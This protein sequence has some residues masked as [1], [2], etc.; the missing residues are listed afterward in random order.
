MNYLN[1]ILV[2]PKNSTTLLFF[3]VY[4]YYQTYV[5]PCENAPQ[6]GNTNQ[7][8][9]KKC[10]SLEKN[11]TSWYYCRVFQIFVRQYHKVSTFWPDI[12]LFSCVDIWTWHLT[13][14]WGP[15]SACAPAAA[16]PPPLP[17]LPAA[18]LEPLAS[19]SARPRR[20]GNNTPGYLFVFVGRWEGA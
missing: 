17:S 19:S 12:S 3:S 4:S 14:F 6:F 7:R 8:L 18:A 2:R 13:T 15:E 10:Q 9:W 16:C 20:L 11:G 1:F 5:E